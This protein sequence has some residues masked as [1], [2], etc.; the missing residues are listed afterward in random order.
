ML[1]LKKVLIEKLFFSLVKDKGQ[2]YESIIKRSEEQIFSDLIKKIYEK[3]YS[4]SC[5]K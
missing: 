5:S 2:Y 1:P 4:R 3:I